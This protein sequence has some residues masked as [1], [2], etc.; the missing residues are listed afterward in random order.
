MTERNGL[1]ISETPRINLVDDPAHP[2]LKAYASFVLND[3]FYVGNVRIVQVGDRIIVAMPSRESKTGEH[4]DQAHP[5]DNAT[6][7][8]IERAILQAY[9]R[10]VE[11]AREWDE[12]TRPD[13]TLELREAC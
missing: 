9:C 2:R 5:V 11:Y 3:A 13:R 4:K 1:R 10:E 7:L 8:W 6:R 12:A